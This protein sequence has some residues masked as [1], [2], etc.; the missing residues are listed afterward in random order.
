MREVLI[1]SL[2]QMTAA[3]ALYREFGFVRAPALDHSPK[4][5]V[6]LWGLRLVLWP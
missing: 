2:P 6:H 3:H 5:Q 4:P 1:S